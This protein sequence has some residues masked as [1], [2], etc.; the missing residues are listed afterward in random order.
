MS[1]FLNLLPQAADGRWFSNPAIVN[2][3]LPA[4]Y[5]TLAMTL[6]STIFTVLL[7]APLGIA[8][9]ATSRGQLFENRAV[10]TILAT[11]VNIGRSVP[12]LILAAAIVPLTRLIAGTILGW[13]ATVIPL[14]VASTPYFA[15]LVET[16][17]LGVAYGKIEAALMMGA[18]RLRILFGVMIPEAAAALVQSTTVLVVTI[19]GYG[20]M[21]GA[22]GSG[23]LGQLA[24][25]YGYNRFEEDVM[26]ITVA[27]IVIIVQLTQ[28]MGDMLSRRVDHR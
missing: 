23:G 28:M 17:I 7:G 21:A 16:S 2:Q 25:N 22:L 20:A 8:L 15:R 26:V 13:Q 6:A 27:A 1:Y 3:F 18:S 19:I 4:L 24:M 14:V 5:E 12:F 10:N 9:V 11:I